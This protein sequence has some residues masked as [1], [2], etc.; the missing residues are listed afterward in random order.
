MAATT[1]TSKN[2]VGFSDRAF[3]M[4]EIDK[5]KCAAFR[6]NEAKFSPTKARPIAV[7]LC[8]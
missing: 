5:I 2:E 1:T 7:E 3:D 4:S 8:K 6:L